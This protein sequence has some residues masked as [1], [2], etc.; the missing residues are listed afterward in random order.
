[1]L[2]PEPLEGDSFRPSPYPK[3]HRKEAAHAGKNRELHVDTGSI[4]VVLIG[5]GLNPSP[6]IRRTRDTAVRFIFRGLAE[7]LM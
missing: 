4:G 5:A 6:E 7:S 1:M 2:P 3:S